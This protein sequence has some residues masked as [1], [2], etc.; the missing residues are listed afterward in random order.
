[1]SCGLQP[2]WSLWACSSIPCPEQDRL[3]VT[4]F[5]L[6]FLIP[7]KPVAFQASYLTRVL[8]LACGS[9]VSLAQLVPAQVGT[10]EGGRT[11][12]GLITA[13][14]VYASICSTL[15][16]YYWVEL[17]TTGLVRPSCDLGARSEALCT[18]GTYTLGA[19]SEVWE[20]AYSG[21]QFLSRQRGCGGERDSTKLLPFR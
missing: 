11:L 12:M 20:R 1:M 13:S 10:S 19:T 16:P 5:A 8:M 3:S 14:A 15:L 18:M 2:A 6:A 21:I 17:V 9:T 4:G 7:L